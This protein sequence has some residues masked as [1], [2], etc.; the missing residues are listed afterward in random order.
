MGRGGSG[1][2]QRLSSG[3]AVASVPNTRTAG[4]VGTA[5]RNVG[6][7]QNIFSQTSLT[8]VNSLNLRL[9]IRS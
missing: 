2:S 3:A 7:I 9:A 6:T 8:I 1:D 5:R 4:G